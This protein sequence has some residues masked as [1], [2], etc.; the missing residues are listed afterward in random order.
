MRTGWE[1]DSGP[2]SIFASVKNIER[3]SPE[4]RRINNLVIRQ[5]LLSRAF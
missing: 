3:R 2:F 4:M 1:F 5:F